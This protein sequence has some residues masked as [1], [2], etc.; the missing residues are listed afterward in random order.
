MK[1]IQLFVSMNVCVQKG[2]L[3]TDAR[4]TCLN[5]MQVKWVAVDWTTGTVFQ[6]G[7]EHHSTSYLMATGGSLPRSIASI[8]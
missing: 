2:E 3:N 6:T 7:C 4:E 1:I 8:A 5:N